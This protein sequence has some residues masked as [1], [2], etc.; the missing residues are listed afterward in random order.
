MNWL[1][2]LAAN[3]KSP[4]KISRL[5][6]CNLIIKFKYVRAC[7][8]SFFAFIVTTVL[9]FVTSGVWSSFFCSVSAGIVTGF[10]F[11]L[12]S[13]L[14][15]YDEYS[16]T[17]QKDNYKEFYKRTENVI[18]RIG[19]IL[20]NKE[21]SDAEVQHIYIELGYSYHFYLAIVDDKRN[22]HTKDRDGEFCKLLIELGDIVGDK[23]SVDRSRETYDN[24]AQILTD[25]YKLL[26]L[27]MPEFYSAMINKSFDLMQLKNNMF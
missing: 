16:T 7:I 22:G 25:I 10:V 18:G 24:Y 19:D 23:N 13:G 8:I 11:F 17:E 9:M 2:D 27:L 3:S 21:L 4:K 20:K 14:K 26:T 1:E 15:T 5:I 6:F 12:I